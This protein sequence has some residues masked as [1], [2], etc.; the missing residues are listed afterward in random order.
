MREQ[1]ER[2]ERA[3]ARLSRVER[4]R[5]SKKPPSTSTSTSFTHPL[6]LVSRKPTPKSPPLPPKQAVRR[7]HPTHARGTPLPARAAGR[8]PRRAQARSPALPGQGEGVFLSRVLRVFDLDLDQKK[9]TQNSQPFKTPPQLYDYLSSSTPAPHA[10]REALAAF[11]LEASKLG[12]SV[13]QAA[14]AANLVPTREVDAFAIAPSLDEATTTTATAG[15]GARAEA[16][17]GALPLIE[18][19]KALQAASDSAEEAK[20]R[21]RA[22]QEAAADRDEAEAKAAAAAAAAAVEEEQD[23]DT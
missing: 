15:Q 16:S 21:K 17:T 3:R 19:C 11:A 14:A 8:G 10:P 4:R 6:T 5:R 13:S 12:L 22:D 9:N 23:D 7:R 18:A 20:G 1:R 2:E